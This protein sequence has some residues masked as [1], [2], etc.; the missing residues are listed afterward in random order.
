MQSVSDEVVSRTS[1]QTLISQSDSMS[2]ESEQ[3][4][5]E[6]QCLSRRELQALAKQEGVRANGSS[7][8]IVNALLAAAAGAAAGEAR[9][10][11]PRVC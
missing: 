4:R 2:P 11:Q 1:H 8:D 10:Q 7:A 6:L 9:L 5:R 3:M